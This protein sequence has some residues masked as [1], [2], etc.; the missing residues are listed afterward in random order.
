MNQQLQD[1]AN[2]AL[3]QM[4]NLSI[5]GINGAI[6][7]SKQ[8]IPDVIHQMLVWNAVS[9]GVRFIIGISFLVGFVLYFKFLVRYVRDGKWSRANESTQF[10]FAML[11]GIVLGVTLLFGVGGCLHSLDWLQIILAP[12]YYLLQQAASLVKGG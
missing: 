6:E 2:K 11:S 5:Q 3:E 12:K 1:T 9:S 10:S 7:F 4:I 8:Q